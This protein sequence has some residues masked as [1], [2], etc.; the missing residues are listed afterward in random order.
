MGLALGGSENQ[1]GSLLV[2]P[3]VT[4]AAA[5][6]FA[7]GG[8]EAQ[9]DLGGVAAGLSWD[10]VG[11][12]GCGGMQRVILLLMVPWQHCVTERQVLLGANL[13]HW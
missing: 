7:C 10:A 12:C 4:A 5:V 3:V 8:S 13:P 1:Q 6:G 11:F 9:W 2:V